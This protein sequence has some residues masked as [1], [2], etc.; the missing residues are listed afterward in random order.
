MEAVLFEGQFCFLYWEEHVVFSI[1]QSLG[2]ASYIAK[3][4][5]ARK[6]I[7]NR[8]L[9]G[10]RNVIL[11]ECS[12]RTVYNMRIDSKETSCDSLFNLIFKS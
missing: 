4:T 3:I 5:L 7:N 9:L 6:F 11:F 2:C 12:A 1:P 8:T 10:G